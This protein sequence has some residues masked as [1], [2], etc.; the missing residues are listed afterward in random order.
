MIARRTLLGAALAMPAIARSARAATTRLSIGYQKIGQLLVL[1]GQQT[2]AARLGKEGVEVSWHEFPSGPPLMEALN[3]GALDFGYAGDS[4]PIFALAA[5]ADIVFVAYQPT[6]GDSEAVLVRKGGPVQTLADLKGKRLA[7]VK[8]SSAHYV[9]LK[10]LQ[11]AG[12]TYADITPVHLQPSDAAAAFRQGAI[13]AWSIWDPYYAIAQQ[14]PQAQV[15]TTG[16]GVSP[17]NSFFLAGRGYAAANPAIISIVVEEITK[18]T[19]YIG[20]HQD[21]LAR[22][23]AEVTGIPEPIERIAAARGSYDTAFMDD[24]AVT[25]EQAIADLY[26]ANHLIPRAIRVRDAVWTPSA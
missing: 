7:F 13:D 14:D 3:A 2:L 20:Q 21:E 22:L 24:K 15:L 12:L 26:Y 25:Q 8:G 19:T 1:K 5:A 17:S 10:V 9:T 4:P 6:P 11:A 16:V 23:M 18:A